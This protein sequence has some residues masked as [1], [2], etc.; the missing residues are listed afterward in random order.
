MRSSRALTRLATILVTAIAVLVSGACVNG[1]G[2]GGT[3][4]PTS[5]SPTS[6]SRSPSPGLSTG[7]QT[8]STAQV[9][10]TVRSAIEDVERYWRATFPGLAGGRPF[11]PLK[12]GYFPYTRSNPPRACGQEPGTYQPNAF[13]CPAG[14][15]IAWDEEVLVPRL[16]SQYG[17]FLVAVVIAHEYG[18]AIQNRLH[19]QGLP[20][21]V[22]EQQADCFAGSWAQDVAAGHSDAFRSLGPDQLDSAVAGMLSIRDQPGSSAQSPQA[23]GNAFDRIRAFQE[24]YEQ[25]PKRCAAYRPGT[26]P[27]TEIPFSDPTDYSTGGNLPYP[28]AVR[29]LS[30]DLQLYWSSTFP[31]LG[32]GAWKPLRV[33]PY[34]PA[35]RPACAGDTRG[36]QEAGGAAY[37]CPAG[38]F[39]A[40]DAGDVGKKLH[41]QIGDNAVGIL[42]ANLFARA[43]LDRLHRPTTGKPA[44]LEIDCLSGA[45]TNSLLER[46]PQ[47]QLQLSP[48][49]LD[50]AV[51][52]LLVFGRG[53][54][55][56]GASSF[57]RIDAYR[58]A[59]LGGISACR[60]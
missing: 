1:G 54:D 41:T 23:H 29:L 58:T 2:P 59:V 13:Y 42:L 8:P 57:E 60:L 15:F 45:W 44:Q 47:A 53:D 3:P 30:A 11:V 50:E 6:S 14:D 5:S 48:G 20:T 51:T 18:H 19:L 56:D 16:Y 28:E 27:I 39:V 21:I 36:M 7:V 22:L 46:G 32:G 25:G 35:P 26:I 37:Y 17:P 12:G 52:T 34:D 55:N 31:R 9:D 4:S 38:S 49:D 33:V 40:F 43:V 24:G 10:K